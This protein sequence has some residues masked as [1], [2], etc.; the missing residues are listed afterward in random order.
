MIHEVRDPDHQVPSRLSV[1]AARF[2][3]SR[4][5]RGG[6]IYDLISDLVA[7]EHAALEVHVGDASA[8]QSA[9]ACA[10]LAGTAAFTR[11]AADDERKRVRDARHDLLNAVGTIRNAIL[12]MDD[13]PSP[14]ARDHFLSIARRNSATAQDLVREHL[15][16]PTAVAAWLDCSRPAVE[17]GAE[18]G[19]PPRSSTGQERG[20]LAGAH[21]RQHGNA[22]LR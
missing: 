11:A 9:A 22:E 17:G 14:E 19:D 16:E 12:L 8:V 15:A 5:S 18:P 4:A 6:A 13:E 21:E 3:S 7:L 20:D 10:L 1:A 2:G